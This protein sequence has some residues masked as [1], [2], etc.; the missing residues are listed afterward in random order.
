MTS[1]EQP[2]S[3][4]DAAAD[5]IATA[6]AALAS[7]SEGSG[8]TGLARLTFPLLHPR[9]FL[10]E[11]T[12]TGPAY[13][14]LVLFG[15]NAVDELDRTAF[16]ILVPEIREEF[17]L[18]FQGLLTFV[19][20][21][22]AASL[23][24][25]I[26]IAGL[27][28][29]HS[30][31]RMALIGASAWAVFS[32]GTG[33]AG[34]LIMLGTMRAGSAIGKAVNDPTHNSLLADYFPVDLRPRVYS[35][36]RAANAV[37]AFVGPLTAG[38]LASAF[39]WRTPFLVFAIPTVIVV[40][41]A[42][43]LR[44]PVRGAQER[45]AMHADEE[46][47]ATEEEP[48][49]YAEAWRM[50]WKV[51]SLRRIFVAMP[52][53]AAS[54]IGFGSLA[55]LLYDEAFGLD[56]KARGFAAAATEPF[57]LVG[58]VIGARMAM[59]LF[60]TDPTKM[61][62]A[63]GWVSV[64]T[65]A[66]SAAF[67]LA[68][69]IWVAMA[70]NACIAMALAI[71]G[72]GILAALSLAIPA[73][74]RSM[75]FSMSSLWV[76][77]GLLILPMI[78]WIAD[79]WGIRQGM[80]MM[81]PVFVIGGLIISSASETLPRD[82]AQVWTTAAARSEVA[83]ERRQGR[84]KQLLVRKLDV[85]YGNVQVLF[86]VDF[87]IDEGEIVA[88]LGT[89]GAGKS[90]LLNAIC[91]VVEADKGAVIFDGRDI[92]H[93]PPNEIAHHGVIQLPGGKAVFPSLTVAE[94]LKAAE[95]MRRD[96]SDATAL[97]ADRDRVFELFPV[98]S[99]R[100]DEPAANMSGGQQQMLAVAMAF[101]T[102]PKLLM[103]DE[104]SLGLA[105]AV[106]ASLLPVLDELRD[107]GVTI[108]LV[109]Q[110]VNVALSVADTA[111]FMEKGEIRFHGPTA[112]LLDRPDILRS[113]FLEGAAGMDSGSPAEQPVPMVIDM[114][115]EAA[116][117][118]DQ[119]VET[120]KSI[121]NTENTESAKDIENA[122]DDLVGATT[123]SSNGLVEAS[124]TISAAARHS[125]VDAEFEAD[126]APA[127]LQVEGATVRFGGNLAVDNVSFDLNS[128]EILGFIG[129]NGAGKTTLF[130]LISGFTAADS[131]TVV[132]DGVDVS[133]FGPDRRARAGLGRSFQDAKLFPSLTVAETLAV[134]L[135]RWVEVK[136]PLAAALYL[137]AVVDSEAAV[138]FRVDELIELMNLGAY[139]SKFLRELSTGSR[140]IVDLACVVAHHPIALLLDEPSSGIAQRETE[141]LVPVLLRLRR[142]LGCSIAVIEHDMPLLRGV[143]DRMV[144]LDQGAVIA[145]GDP[146]AVLNDPQVVSSYLGDNEVTIERSGGTT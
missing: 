116:G 72:P 33:L 74:A 87:E 110:S 3:E 67:A 4:A 10:D 143:A 119:N 68:P 132:L 80:L 146:A 70:I 49:S 24:L 138:E 105:P 88:L 128:G 45:R 115:D 51:E 27:A 126:A 7:T 69:N 135:E 25:Q 111:Y 73:R 56:E 53:L 129:P 133:K 104:L 2:P 118:D 90:T 9:R 50:C 100:L 43:K 106:V 12:G 86:D 81:V 48:P 19:A 6:E 121:K 36:H 30:R 65:S 131:G 122:V 46:A 28:D 13:A 136:D 145:S 55:A 59:K 11:I 8:R 113:V 127:P 125:D 58:L 20:L 29:R 38:L 108:I 79:N 142:E 54:L 26:P 39:G 144:A 95:W 35:F 52:F 94:N 97:A 102:K 76:L 71:V 117:P 82:I 99:Q 40:L 66:L 18:G 83:H 140:R 1:V 141:A 85:A 22:I 89:N 84:S 93:A 92:T 61:L 137:P 123:G 5:S 107:S 91:G 139:R 44:E 31:V 124:A 47:I 14:L 32:F 42:V 63:L 64:L 16:A 101:I 37:G 96:G 60:A 57:A 120:T 130:D 34:G 75:G 15:L 114:R 103:I 21:V 78:G 134:A 112:E 17:N 98:L 109:E 41:L 23:A 77:P 62:R